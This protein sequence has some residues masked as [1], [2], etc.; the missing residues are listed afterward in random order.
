[1]NQRISSGCRI[2][3]L[4]GIRISCLSILLVLLAGCSES[5][6][7]FLHTALRGEAQ[8]KHAFEKHDVEGAELAAA[9]AEVALADLE[10]FISSGKPSGLEKERLLSQTRIAAAAARDY[11]QLAHEELL[12]LSKLNGLKLKSYQRVRG[13]VCAYTIAGLASAA[14]RLALAGTNSSS[15]EQQLASVAWKMVEIV[16]SGA[17]YT[18]D[19]PSWSAAARTLRAC[20]SNPPPGMGMA[21]AIA[22]A[23]GG[24]TDFALSE[25][26]TVK[27]SQLASTNSRSLYHVE[28]GALFAL[29]GW[30]R[31]AARELAQAV[32][33]APNGWKTAGVTQAVSVV[34]FWLAEQ[35][36]NRAN[37]VQADIETGEVLKTWPG[38]PLVTLV[39]SDKMAANGQW[40]KAA[41][42]LDEGA[43]NIKNQWLATRLT[44]RA[45][46]IR[47]AQGPG[48]QL[49]SDATLL[50]EFAAH[51]A[52]DSATAKSLL[53]GLEQAKALS[54]QA[55]DKIAHLESNRG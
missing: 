25:I 12:R 27:E 48:P 43:H 14:D 4:R 41:D 2:P 18:N 1:M 33:L 42:L 26:E 16:D 9:R 19:P 24:L 53:Q 31:S 51:A 22:Y 36:L 10:Q 20:S 55:A 28:R 52:G 39:I 54:G 13:A 30:D 32:E 11:A 35:S 3:F 8:A 49:F 47:K 45:L 7:S 5:P 37:Y 50:I 44:Q 23:V 17:S 21:L 15:A 6:S 38:N 40:Q 29:H 46:D 34:H